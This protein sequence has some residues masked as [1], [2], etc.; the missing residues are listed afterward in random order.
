M[1]QYETKIIFYLYFWTCS[2][3]TKLIKVISVTINLIVSTNF[4]LNDI[5]NVRNLI[6]RKRLLK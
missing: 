2:F 4:S 6:K 5:N 3:V 1:P